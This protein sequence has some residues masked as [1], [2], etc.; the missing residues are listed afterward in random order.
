MND[1]GL[2]LR[3]NRGGSA[4]GSRLARLSFTN[5]SSL[6]SSYHPGFIPTLSPAP[7]KPGWGESTRGFAAMH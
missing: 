1:R 7:P 5:Q 3:V 4:R 6:E 2:G